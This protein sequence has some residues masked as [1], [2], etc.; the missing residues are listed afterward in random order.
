MTDHQNFNAQPTQQHTQTNT[1]ADTVRDANL[2]ATIWRNEG[3]KGA[4]Y[5]TTLAKTYQD[6]NGNYKDTQTFSQNDLLRVSELARTAYNRVTE[7][8]RED[9]RQSPEHTPQQRAEKQQFMENRQA[10]SPQHT[11]HR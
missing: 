8:R 1:P 10:H 2:K 7:L 4:Y 6:Q 5:N 3:E 11:R 9:H